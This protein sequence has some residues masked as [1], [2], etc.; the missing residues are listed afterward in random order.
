MLGNGFR[1]PLTLP[2]SSVVNWR[3]AEPWNFE[4]FQTDVFWGHRVRVFSIVKLWLLCL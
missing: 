2:L 3:I 4:R 1:A